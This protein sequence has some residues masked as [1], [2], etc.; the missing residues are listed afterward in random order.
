MKLFDAVPKDLFSILASPNKLIYADALEVLYQAYLENLKIPEDMLYSMLRGKLEQQLAEATFEGEDIDEEELHDI[1]GRVRF[2]IRKLGSRGWFQKERGLDFKEY[3]TIPGYSSRILEVL[4][5]LTDESPM[6]GYSYVFSTYSTLKVANEGAQ[7]YEKMTAVYSAY[8]NTQNLEKLLRM[9]HHNVKH[10]FQMQIE[11]QDVNEV[12]HSHFND[13]GLKVIETYIRPLKIKD[14]VPK[15][16]VPIQSILDEWLEDDA[17]LHAMAHT[18]FQDRRGETVEVCYNDLLRKIYWIKDRYERME[19]EY[20][21]EI[22][23]QVRRYTRATTQKIENL[24]NRDQNL[25]GNLNELL[26]MMAQKPRSRELLEQ[27]QPVFQLYEQGYLSERSLW[28]RKRG[29]K[30]EK[31]DPVYIEE[32]ALDAEAIAEAQSILQ[33]KYGRA[34]VL[35]YMQERFGDRDFLYSK[36]FP[37][38]DDEA[39][40]MSLFAVLDSRDSFYSFEVL[41]GDYVQA[42][43]QI[44]QMKFVSKEGKNGH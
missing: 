19:Q 16:R 22:D 27:I 38:L 15:Y 2:L 24:T 5:Q 28:I 4:H 30:R 7:V 26:T 13:F 10:Y 33:S 9:V 35:S 36:D 43:Y 20:L 32:A 29:V 34:A 39:Y 18:A 3:I 12:L 21:E 23:A 1:S 42:Q 17:L 41:D 11:M 6:R 40:I 44:P 8:E 37:L 14:S 25:R 31:T